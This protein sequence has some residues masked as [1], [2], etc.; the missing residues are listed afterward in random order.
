VI[1][2]KL[3]VFVVL[4]VSRTDLLVVP[5]TESCFRND[6]QLPSDDPHNIELRLSM[7]DRLIKRPM[8]LKQKYLFVCNFKL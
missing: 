4:S 7:K 2:K 6:Q 1:E 5:R 3:F 8:I